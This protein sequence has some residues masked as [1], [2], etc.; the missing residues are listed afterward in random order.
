MR[1]KELISVPLRAE[2]FY[3]IILLIFYLLPV[4]K[5]LS[6][7]C[8]PNIDFEN[9][10]F[11]GWTCYTGSVAGV[12]GEN[13]ISLQPSG[14][15]FGQHEILSALNNGNQRDY[16]GDFPVVC[17]NGSGY[18]VKLGNVI[19]GAQAEGISYEF[20]VPSNRN[21][22]SLIYYYAV[23]FQDPNHQPFQQPRLVLEVTNVTDN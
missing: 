5:T 23:V 12:N 3:C 7:G 18:S 6:Q 20:T 8:P 19:G 9:G 1:E 4:H 14:P 17:P 2:W 21:T 16:Y 15:L 10:S 22:Y 11:N 13:I